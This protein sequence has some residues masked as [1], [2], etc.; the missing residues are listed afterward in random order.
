[1]LKSTI[2]RYRLSLGIFILGL[3]FSGLTAFPLLRELSILSPILG[4]D[5]PANYATYT[6]LRHW[7]AYVHFALIQTYASFPFMAYGTDWLAFGHL[8][9][10]LFFIGPFVDPLRNAWVLYCGLAA[11]AAEFALALIC[12]PIRHI[13]AYWQMIDCSFGVIGS[14]PIFYCLYLTRKLCLE[15]DVEQ[16]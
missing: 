7:I 14:L 1:M 11:C 16:K 8:I 5:D 12:G 10:A 13:P 3:V 4:I 2:K 9:I 6:G 15:K